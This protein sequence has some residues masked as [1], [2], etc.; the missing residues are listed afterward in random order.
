LAAAEAAEI[1]INPGL[2]LVLVVVVMVQSK[3]QQA[4]QALLTPVVVAE[5]QLPIIQLLV[6]VAQAALATH[7]LHIGLKHKIFTAGKT[8]YNSTKG[9]TCERN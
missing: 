2:L 8:C 4:A 7:E 9:V 1:E 5:A 3:T 6:M